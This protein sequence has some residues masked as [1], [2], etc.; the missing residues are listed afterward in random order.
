VTDRVTQRGFRVR[1]AGDVVP[2]GFPLDL[3]RTTYWQG[4]HMLTGWSAEIGREVDQAAARG[5]AGTS[6][7]GTTHP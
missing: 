3:A 1:V 5:G 6:S 2:Q 7:Y 4:Q